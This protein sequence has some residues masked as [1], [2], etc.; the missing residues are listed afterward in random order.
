MLERTLVIIKPNAVMENNWFSI[1][2]MYEDAGLQIERAEFRVSLPA[3]TVAS[4][5][6]ENEGKPVYPGLTTFMAC[7]PSIVLCLSGEDAIARVR[8]LNGATRPEEAA[9]GTIRRVYGLFGFTP[10]NA[11]H[12]SANAADAERELA[13]IFP[14]AWFHP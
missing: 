2:K 4:L 9:P 8:S 13:L 5:Y 12:G 1:M 7:G 3:E 14:I 11:V 6:R 10:A